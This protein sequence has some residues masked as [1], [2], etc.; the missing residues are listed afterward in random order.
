MCGASIITP[1][2]SVTA[3]HCVIQTKMQT[4]PYFDLERILINSKSVLQRIIPQNTASNALTITNTH[5]HPL[6]TDQGLNY[7]IAVVK[8]K[9]PVEISPYARPVCLLSPED[10]EFLSGDSN[11]DIECRTTGYGSLH[12]S[13]AGSHILLSSDQ[14][15]VY[16]PKVISFF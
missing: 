10:D 15:L 16:A 11:L 4:W 6:Y 9:S 12:F 7:D 3:A 2:W 1:S 13:Q 5:I 14:R 8:R